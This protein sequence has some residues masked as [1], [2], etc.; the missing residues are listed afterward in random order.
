[1]ECKIE[2][3][4]TYAKKLRNHGFYLYRCEFKGSLRTCYDKNGNPF[5]GNVYFFIFKHRFFPK[6]Y[7]EL[8]NYDIQTLNKP[9][10]HKNGILID[11]SE[12]FF[13]PSYWDNIFGIY[14]KIRNTIYSKIWKM[15]RR[16]RNS[17]G[18]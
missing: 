7:A 10:L 12:R 11:D 5:K 13:V 8:I 1:M 14:Y 2:K 3:N 18:L 6:L 16:I 15:K 17:Y 9:L 4:S